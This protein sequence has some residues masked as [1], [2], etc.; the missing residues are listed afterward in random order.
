MSTFTMKNNAKNT[1]MAWT[2][3]FKEQP[4]LVDRMTQVVAYS[5]GSE[6]ECKARFE[7]LQLQFSPNK[8]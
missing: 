8:F 6:N 1:I 2:S 7:R 5:D 4:V 3:L